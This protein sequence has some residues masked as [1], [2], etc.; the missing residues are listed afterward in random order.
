VAAQNFLVAAQ[1]A[2]VIRGPLDRDLTVGRV[3]P[4]EE[5]AAAAAAPGVL[6]K[7]ESAPPSA[8]PGVLGKNGQW[9]IRHRNH[10][11]SHLMLYSFRQ[12]RPAPLPNRIRLSNGFTRYAHQPPTAEEILDA[13]YIAYTEPAY[14]AATEQL[15]WVDGAY[16]IEALPPPIP[17]PRWVDFS[18]IVMSL[19]AINVMLGAVL[20][21]APGLYGG[22]VVGLQNASEGD[23]RVFLNSWNAAFAMGLL[24]AELITTVQQLAAEYDL[25]EAFIDALG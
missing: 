10:P 21:A 1:A 15:L 4:A 18:A 9:R 12:Q 24:S 25:P 22:L 6:E 16:V 13:G 19:P 20:Q 3:V 17:T 14:D 7:M 23:S 2:R 11:L 8:A 5:Y